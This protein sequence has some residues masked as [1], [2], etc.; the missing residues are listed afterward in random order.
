MVQMT[1]YRYDAMEKISNRPAIRII[2][3][4]CISTMIF[5]AA[6][7]ST[8]RIL[9]EPLAYS[10]QRN[11][12][13]LDSLALVQ[14]SSIAAVASFL[15]WALVVICAGRIALPMAA[16]LGSIVTWVFLSAGFYSVEN[17]AGVKALSSGILGR[18]TRVLADG[19]DILFMPLIIPIVAVLSGIS[20][21]LGLVIVR[22]RRLQSS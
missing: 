13:V 20:L 16:G 4:L 8:L 3:S 11:S 7:A 1:F 17:L 15:S 18:A 5:W 22:A 21:F 19:N 2:A 14:A 6:T 12:M 10:Q 9:A